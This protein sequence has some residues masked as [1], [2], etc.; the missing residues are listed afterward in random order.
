MN[1]LDEQGL[2][3]A[4]E[5]DVREQLER[6]ASADLDDAEEKRRWQRVKQRAPE[7]WTQSGA[8][9]ILETVVSAAIKSGLGL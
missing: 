9:A 7:F 5:L 2:D 6:L 3:P 1:L 4:T 8:R